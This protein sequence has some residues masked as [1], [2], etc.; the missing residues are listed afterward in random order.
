MK[1]QSD[2]KLF[3]KYVLLNIISMAGLSCYILA[4]T[5]YVANGLGPDGLAS[6]NLAIPVFS[7]I[8]GTGMML[9]IGGGTLFAI[10]KARKR[11]KEAENIFM[12]MFYGA[13]F[14]AVIFV[15]GGIFFHEKIAVLLGAGTDTL[16]MTESYIR[17]ILLFSPAFLFNNLMNCF[18][19]N[20]GNPQVAMAAMVSGS[21]VN[22]V[23][24]YIFIFPMGMGMKGAALATGSAPVVGL[25]ILSLH[26]IKK[27][28]T[29]KLRKEKPGFRFFRSC[30]PLGIPSLVNEL[31]S[32]IVIIV[33]NLLILDIAGNTGVAAYGIIANIS[34]VVI[35]VYTGI[36]QGIQ[37]VISEAY[38]KEMKDRIKNILKYGILLSLIISA[39]ICIF[40]M[41]QTN[42][43]ISFFNHEGNRAL[44]QIAAKGI[45]LYFAAIPFAGIN[46]VMCSY[47]ASVEKK[48]PAHI[49]SL[50]RGF[51]LILPLVVLMAKSIGLTGIWISFPLTE[52]ITAVFCMVYYYSRRRKTGY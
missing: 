30:I 18:V 48:V 35:A 1:E 52:L 23:F 29:F 26:F 11:E 3:F 32:G 50:A 43:V 33:F 31:S 9:G 39:A 28:N 40:L 4:D 44:Q 22:I 10:M 2:L 19:K 45:R 8:T 25:L 7:F 20:D 15:L 14:F 16:E 24:D 13:S 5:F 38:G 51:I 42:Q 36:A 17:I 27:K 41:I 49:I 12:N 21:L 47:Y 6:L 46:I 37:P 34:L